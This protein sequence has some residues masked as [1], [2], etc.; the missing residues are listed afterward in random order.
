MN[1]H[2]TF[3]FY[4]KKMELFI[5]FIRTSP[6]TSN[7]TDQTRVN[8]NASVI[9]KLITLMNKISLTYNC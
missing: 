6:S 5:L 9:A 1:N 7:Q 3:N 8:T 2:D 4:F